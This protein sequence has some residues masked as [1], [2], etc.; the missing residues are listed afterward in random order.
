MPTFMPDEHFIAPPTADLPVGVRGGLFN[1]PYEQDE[2][3]DDPIAPMAPVVSSAS[4]E[5]DD[6]ELQNPYAE[7]DD[8]DAAFAAG[9]T[10]MAMPEEATDH[11]A[12]TATPAAPTAAAPYQLPDELAVRFPLLRVIVLT[13]LSLGFFGVYWFFQTR[14]QVSQL[15]DDGGNPW[16]HTVGLFV[17][18]W[19]LITTVL[20]WKSIRDLNDATQT[21]RIPLRTLVI[22]L[23]APLLLAIAAPVALL[24]V[25]E[26]GVMLVS[27]LSGVFGLIAVICYILVQLRLN[28][29]LATLS[30]QTPAPKRKISIVCIAVCL[31]PLL[32]GC[33]GGALAG[34]LIGTQIGPL[35]DLVPTTQTALVVR[36][37][38]TVER[39]TAVVADKPLTPDTER[40][41]L[42][43]AEYFGM[44]VDRALL[45]VAYAD[46]ESLYQQVGKDLTQ[47]LDRPC[48]GDDAAA[49]TRAFTDLLNQHTDTKRNL[50]F[51][52]VDAG[53]DPGSGTIG[54]TLSVPEPSRATDAGCAWDFHFS[55]Q[56]PDGT[57]E[58]LDAANG[59][60]A[61]SE[62]L[63]LLAVDESDPIGQSYAAA[64]PV[65]PLQAM[66]DTARVLD[67]ERAALELAGDDPGACPPATDAALVALQPALERFGLPASSVVAMAELP[68]DGDTTTAPG[69][70]GLWSDGSCN[71]M[72]ALKST[73]VTGRV[74]YV[75][76]HDDQTIS[77]N[78][79]V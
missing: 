29:S 66:I 73:S 59:T 20:L 50:V 60:Y 41:A 72:I 17:P 32:G 15:L 37:P 64:L 45:T 5:D 42:I 4:V 9:L 44:L 57:L 28:A 11:S 47:A 54:V 48:S 10:T 78:A 71:I 56:S 6:S 16:L 21:K 70:V 3:Q 35:L 53:Q 13:C 49:A 8:R 74:W 19:N 7:V 67:I 51:I 79:R 27:A 18:V 43:F 22:C 23:V 38:D 58:S 24:T 65:F 31:L 55:A 1:E 46:Q 26:Q 39:P 30:G 40:E 33:A 75:H 52:A 69:V 36:A 12:P 61:S 34:T 68:A 76:H 14:K 25:G 77:Q 63:Q 62:R 2:I